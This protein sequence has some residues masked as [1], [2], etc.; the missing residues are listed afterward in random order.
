MRDLIRWPADYSAT[1]YPVLFL[2]IGY[3]FD[4]DVQQAGTYVQRS[5]LPG[6]V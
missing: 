2:Y 3:P 6:S 4:N 1:G 5:D